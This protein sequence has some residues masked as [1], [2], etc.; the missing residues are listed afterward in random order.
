MD[1]REKGARP[2]HEGGGLLTVPRNHSSLAPDWK[3]AA[4]VSPTT[5]APSE[6]SV[7]SVARGQSSKSSVDTDGH[8]F[9]ALGCATAA[10]C[11]AFFC[12][13]ALDLGFWAV[14][15]AALAVATRSA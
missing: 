7:Y 8:R 14:A 13:L 9:W 10:S 6:S 1:G 11:W 2:A 15:L 4:I 3:V 12:F 5:T